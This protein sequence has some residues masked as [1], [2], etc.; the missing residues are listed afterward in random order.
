MTTCD[1]PECREEL[2]CRINKRVSIRVLMISILALVGVTGSSILYGMTGEKEQTEK[3]A[4]NKSQIELI[5]NDLKHISESMKKIEDKQL[6]KE[7]F[8]K[9]IK[10][11]MKN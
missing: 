8:I 7:E 4:N 1:N 9:I 6:T 5:K 3:V 10:E 11:A 2:I